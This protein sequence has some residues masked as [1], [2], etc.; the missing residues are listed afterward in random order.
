MMLECKRL[1]KN[2]DYFR[3]VSSNHVSYFF[4]LW[5]FDKY[6]FRIPLSVAFLS[7]PD[8]LLWLKGYFTKKISPLTDF[9]VQDRTWNL[10]ALVVI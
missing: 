9:C 6:Y 2:Q 1:N 4:F 5:N 7:I 10:F 8:S 3:P